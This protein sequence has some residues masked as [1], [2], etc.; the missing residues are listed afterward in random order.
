MPG[1]IICGIDK[2]TTHAYKCPYCDFESDDLENFATS[3]CWEC[4]YK[5]ED[6]E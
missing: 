1:I 3:M 4:V 5:P 2:G 6:A